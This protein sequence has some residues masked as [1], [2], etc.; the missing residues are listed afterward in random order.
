MG[1]EQNAEAST[2]E[3]CL[4][5]YEKKAAGLGKQACQQNWL[6]VFLSLQARLLHL[7][8]AANCFLAAKAAFALIFAM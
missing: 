1:Q 8:S 6:R 3:A 7:G 5:A 4:F 2:T